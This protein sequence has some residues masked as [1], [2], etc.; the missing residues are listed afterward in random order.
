MGIKMSSLSESTQAVTSARTH[1]TKAT[2]VTMRG[3][4][5]DTIQTQGGDNIVHGGTLEF[6]TARESRDRKIIEEQEGDVNSD[7]FD[8]TADVHSDN[9][10]IN[11]SS[12]V[13]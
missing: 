12:Y 11:V 7:S 8:E 13:Q 2:L 5:F 1:F 10:G 6:Q 4:E 9:E 3:H